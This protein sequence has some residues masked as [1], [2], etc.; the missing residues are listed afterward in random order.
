MDEYS[1]VLKIIIWAAPIVF[2]VTVHEVAHGWVASNPGDQTAKFL[3]RLTFN[4]IK[5]VDPV[6]TVIVSMV[7][8]FIGSFIFG[9]AKLVSVNWRN[10]NNPKR[11]MALVIIAEPSVNLLMIIF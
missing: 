1:L 10:L 7:L 3:G 11:D 6:G 2:A 9:L 8:L 5:H 4:P